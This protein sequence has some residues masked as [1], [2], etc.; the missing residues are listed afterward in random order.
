MNA[1]QRIKLAQMVE[2]LAHKYDCKSF[3]CEHEAK[4]ERIDIEFGKVSVMFNI[5]ADYSIQHWWGATENLNPVVFGSDAVNK[6]HHRKA[7][8]YKFNAQ[9]L[10]ILEFIFKSIASGLAFTV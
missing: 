3:S 8:V 4:R 2:E 6:Y 9:L 7:T 5:E 10:D 1:R